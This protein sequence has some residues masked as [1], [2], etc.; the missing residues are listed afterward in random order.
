MSSFFFL[1]AT[2]VWDT[3]ALWD[4][5]LFLLINKS[6][7][8]VF[9]DVLLPIWRSRNTWFPLYL[10]MLLVVVR[11]LGYRSIP[12]II[13]IALAVAFGDIISS[14]IIKPYFDRVRPCAEAALLGEM[15]LRIARCPGHGS[16]TSSH[17]T[18]HFAIASFVFFSLQPFLKG[19]RWLFMLWA[20]IICFAQVYVG[21]HYPGDV[22][23]GMM[24]GILLGY[25]FA[26][27]YNRYYRIKLWNKNAGN[28][29]T[30][31]PRGNARDLMEK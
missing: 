2:S 26:Y 18:N 12:W 1:T 6:C 13:G 15:K 22:L 19:W 10:L 21:V 14:H 25:L 4:R 23:G 7:S 17:A 24:L 29:R 20:F 8:S 30:T 27:L 5:E 16:F 11:R 3:L 28:D 31:Q 9:L